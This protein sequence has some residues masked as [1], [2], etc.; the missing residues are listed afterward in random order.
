MNLDHKNESTRYYK[1][2]CSTAGPEAGT[3]QWNCLERDLTQGQYLEQICIVIKL[4]N[5]RILMF[6]LF[7][8]TNGKIL[9]LSLFPVGIT[10]EQLHVSICMKGKFVF[11]TLNR[12]PIAGLFLKG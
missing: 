10:Q 9:G 11:R 2:L 5:L 7:G 3:V 4:Q 12:E 6:V 1:L 8:R